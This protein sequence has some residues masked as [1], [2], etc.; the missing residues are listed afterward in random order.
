[1]GRDPFIAEAMWP[2]IED[3][4]NSIERE[5]HVRV[6]L[7]V[8]SGSRAWRF[9]SPD[10]DYDVRFIYAHTPDSYLSIEPPRD[11]IERP[12]DG[13][14]DINGWDV[15]KALQLLVR[16]NAVLLEWLT[17]PVRYRDSGLAPAR[18]LAL[19]RET[20]YLPA[21]T[22]HYDRLARHSFDDIVSSGGSVRFKTYCYALRAVLALLWMRRHGEPP[23]MDAPTLLHGIVV[24]D[25]VRRAMTELID[26][27]AA[28]AEQDMTARVALLDDFIAGAVIETERRFTLPDRTAV[29]SQANALFATTVLGD[30]DALS[31]R[32]FA[33]PPPRD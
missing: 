20:S 13:V 8:E 23:P 19:A 1:M 14:V 7:A 26:R 6:L 31:T 18:I 30:A 10:S 4:L 29:L 15:R 9:P 2:R 33:P 5:H 28:A 3:E 16:S 24:A 11:V 25:N 17:S 21:M 22:Y 32:G 12:S 27:K